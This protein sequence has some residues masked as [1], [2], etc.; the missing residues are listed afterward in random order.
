MILFSAFTAIAGEP[1]KVSGELYNTG[2]GISIN[3]W[4]SG[5]QLPAMGGNVDLTI[6]FGG[7][8]VG[9]TDL[10]R[11]VYSFVTNYNLEILVVFGSNFEEMN[12]TAFITLLNEYNAFLNGESAPAI[13][14]PTITAPDY[15]MIVAIVDVDGKIMVDTAQTTVSPR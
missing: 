5:D 6:S 15:N 11:A 7:P 9:N 2:N 10:N 4:K 14:A 13:K 1:V 8:F 3:C 12:M